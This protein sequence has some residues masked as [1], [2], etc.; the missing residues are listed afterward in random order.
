MMLQSRRKFSN[1][2]PVVGVALAIITTIA[3]D[4]RNSLP[5]MIVLKQENKSFHV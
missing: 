3:M 5:K 2:H 4:K 1:P